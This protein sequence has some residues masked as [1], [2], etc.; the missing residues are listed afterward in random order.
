VHSSDGIRKLIFDRA[1][2]G[3]SGQARGIDKAVPVAKLM[4]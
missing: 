2:V 3:N 4:N 1:I